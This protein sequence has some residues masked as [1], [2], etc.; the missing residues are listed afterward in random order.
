[1]SV[2]WFS[3]LGGTV[4]CEVTRADFLFLPLASNLKTYHEVVDEIYYRVDHAEPLSP[5][6]ARI[7]S[8]CFCLLQ[9][10]FL[11][12]LTMKQM[13]GLL[14][15]TVRFVCFDVHFSSFLCCAF[16]EA[17]WLLWCL[18]LVHT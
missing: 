10:F 16:W 4:E 2:V 17:D 1:M 7:P 6:T 8:T 9:K 11:M 18:L 5:G 13:Q 3:L 15:H 12:R 14:K